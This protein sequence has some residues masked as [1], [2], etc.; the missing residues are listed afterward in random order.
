MQGTQL[1]LPQP[2]AASVFDA[3]RVLQAVK[4][5]GQSGGNEAQ[6][7]GVPAASPASKPLPDSCSAPSVEGPS[8]ANER[9]SLSTR[10]S[11]LGASSCGETS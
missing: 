4:P 9:S 8:S 10:A 7:G 1:G 2:W 3:Q 5:A 6:T 11:L